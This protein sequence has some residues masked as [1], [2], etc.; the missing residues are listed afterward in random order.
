[1]KSR[2]AIGVTAAVAT[3]LLYGSSFVFTKGAVEV[4]TPAALLA[5]RFVSALALTSYGS[6][7]WEV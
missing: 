6:T 7:D 4:L 1:M 2:T 3:E 5:W